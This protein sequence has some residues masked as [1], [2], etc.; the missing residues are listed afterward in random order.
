[1]VAVTLEMIRIIYFMLRDNAPYSGQIV[2]MITRKLKRVK[3][4]A[5]VG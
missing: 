4:R 1:M 5:S 2:E 3:Y